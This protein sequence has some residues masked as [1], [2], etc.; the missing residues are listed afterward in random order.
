[1]AGACG[2]GPG[3][4]LAEFGIA[5]RVGLRRAASVSTIRMVF[6]NSL[7]AAGIRVQGLKPVI[8]LAS[9]DELKPYLIR[10][11]LTLNVPCMRTVPMRT[12]PMRT[13]Q[14]RTLMSEPF[15]KQIRK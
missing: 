4:G 12:V 8:F 14:I 3:V 9:R 5:G 7:R 11:L 6:I 10:T 1:V 13:V 2:L 15:T